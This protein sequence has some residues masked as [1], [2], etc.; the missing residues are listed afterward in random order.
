MDHS[1]EVKMCLA[2]PGKVIE[3]HGNTAKVDF[4]EGTV[5][6]VNVSLVNIKPGQYVLVHT[7]FAIQV[8]NEEDAIETIKAWE[9]I[10]KEM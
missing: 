2:I 3:V 1:E 10:I 6:E 8:M 4:G 7:G 5:R 9:S